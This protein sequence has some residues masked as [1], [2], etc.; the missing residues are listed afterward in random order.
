MRAGSLHYGFCVVEPSNDSPSNLSR[1]PRRVRIR[2]F[3]SQIARNYHA[4]DKS[5]YRGQLVPG[6]LTS[7]IFRP[8]T[9]PLGPALL[10]RKIV[11]EELFDAER[12]F[13]GESRILLLKRNRFEEVQNVDVLVF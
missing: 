5:H 6:E 1:K 2:D 11:S 8:F 10:Y 9:E 12:T 3:N 7:M 13:M 4:Q